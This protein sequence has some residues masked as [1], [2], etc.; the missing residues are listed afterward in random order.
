MILSLVTSAALAGSLDGKTFDVTITDPQHKSEKDALQF[1]ADTFL[2]PGCE[3]YGFAK[4]AYT[5]TEAAGVWKVV[6]DQASAAEGKNH[7]DLSVTGS[8]IEGTLLWTKAGQD[9]IRYAVAGELHK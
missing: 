4:S 6:V 5:A 7:W 9:P 2:S 3:K 1:A 8:H